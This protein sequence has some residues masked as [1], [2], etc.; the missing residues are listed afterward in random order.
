MLLI[1]IHWCGRGDWPGTVRS[2]A[3]IV[4]SRANF[5]RRR[6]ETVRHSGHVG[7]GILGEFNSEVQR[8]MKSWY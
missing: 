4:R 6:V 5:A 8:L 2:H 7:L 1:E 3:A